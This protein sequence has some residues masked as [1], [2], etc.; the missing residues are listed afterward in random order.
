M[1]ASRRGDPRLALA[2]PPTRL[3][4]KTWEQIEGALAL[5][6]LVRLAI[7][8]DAHAGYDLCIG[9]VALLEDHISPSFVGY[10]I[11][12]G[13]CHVNTGVP[14]DTLL[15]DIPTRRRLYDR[16]RRDVPVGKDMRSGAGL[17]AARFRS[18]G[19]DARL[20]K[21]VNDKAARQMGTLG[22]GNHFIEVGVNARG[23]VGITLHTG[24]RRPGW[25]IA[26]WYMKRGRLFRLRSDL[27]QAYLEDMLW[28]QRYALA[29]RHT[30]LEIILRA[31]DAFTED[32][33]AG[34]VRAMINENHNHALPR[35]S[36][37]LH[38][39][40]ATPA[41]AGQPGIIPANQR[42]GVYL[43]RGLGNEY[44]LSSASHGAG[45]AMP[46]HQAQR[47]ITPETFRSQM[48]G[49]LC[50]SDVTVLDEAPDAYKPIADVLAAQEGVL[51]TVTDHFR[52]VI[53]IK[54]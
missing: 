29:N 26:A 6:C 5:D 50:R 17:K 31:F 2:I 46:R 1:H 47:D 53:V 7:M 51:V 41:D 16:L 33:I 38:R 9:G 44:F 35:G 37:V 12:C 18:A 20:T 15:P 49:V 34:Y 52:P 45:R 13:M 14:V 22:G 40:G 21:E 39:K 36:R 32:E 8:P 19:D 28:A 27:G 54:G 42:D 48:R 24:S 43:T 4:A 30:L 10:D 11:G 23:E 25:D 3:D